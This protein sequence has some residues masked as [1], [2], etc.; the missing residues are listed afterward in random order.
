MAV[1][2]PNLTSQFP[3]NEI[4]GILKTFLP[5]CSALVVQHKGSQQTHAEFNPLQRDYD[6]AWSTWMRYQYRA[7][8]S[9]L[10]VSWV[11]V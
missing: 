10:V 1:S 3:K 5:N 9:H 2:R 6:V 8:W 4:L 11:T 7:C